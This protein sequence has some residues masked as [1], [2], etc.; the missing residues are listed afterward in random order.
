[1]QLYTTLTHTHRQITVQ[2]LS[3]SRV[4]QISLKQIQAKHTN[5]LQPKDRRLPSHIP[6]T[7]QHRCHCYTFVLVFGAMTAL[8]AKIL[9]NPYRHLAFLHFTHMYINHRCEN[10]WLTPQFNAATLSLDHRVAASSCFSQEV[11][12][13][14]GLNLIS[15]HQ[16]ELHR[17][18]QT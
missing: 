16:S 2:R 6:E 18:Q 14:S 12:S 5:K 4:C 9:P 8:T 13:P 11:Y 15:A 7:W 1:M 3:Q 10:G 17:R